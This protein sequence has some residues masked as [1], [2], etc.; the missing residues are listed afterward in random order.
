MGRLPSAALCFVLSLVLVDSEH[1]RRRPGGL[2][3]DK[4][5]LMTERYRQPRSEGNQVQSERTSKV[6][7]LDISA[8]Q[9]SEPDSKGEYTGAHIDTGPLPK[10]FTVCSAFSAKAWTG[11]YSGGDFFTMNTNEGYR[12]GYINL[13]AA[14]MYSEIEVKL[15]PAFYTRL[16]PRILFPLEWMH[17]CLH[18]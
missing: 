18:I 17:A 2:D 13:W 11:D 4:R 14:T 15:G 3:Q 10:T 16:H 12:W 5:A 1:P 6:K 8:D 9:D 7:I